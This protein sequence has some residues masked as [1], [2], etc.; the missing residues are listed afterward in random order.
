MNEQFAQSLVNKLIAGSLAGNSEVELLTELCRRL[1]DFGLPLLRVS[2]AAEQLHPTIGG[3]GHVWWRDA[4]V[5][6]PSFPR[7]DSSQGLEL[8]RRSPFD[9]LLETGKSNGRFRLQE[10]GQASE[11]PLFAELRQRG[12]SEYFAVVMRIDHYAT[13]SSARDVA[14]SWCTDRPDG[15]DETDVVLIERISPALALVVNSARST[16]T[17]RFLLETYLGSDAANRVLSGNVV[18]GRADLIEAAIWFSDLS[19]FT[20]TFDKESPT[21][22]LALLNEYANLQCEAIHAQGGQV[23]KFIG[24]GILATFKN[25]DR[26]DACESAAS[27][28]LDALHRAALLSRERE[29]RALPTTAV[30]IALHFGEVLYG[31]FGNPNRLDFT[32][33]GPAVNEASR[34]VALSG[35]LDQQLIISEVVAQALGKHRDRIAALGRHTLKGVAKP[36]LLFA[37]SQEPD[38][39]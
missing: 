8:Q 21:T 18:R 2:T 1:V 5:E 13:L 16:A 17:G 23:L 25:N 30:K 12:A 7:R 38:D 10:T 19:G 22:V 11:F 34:I 26:R 24:D 36:Q 28:A 14:F 3:Q 9:H 20:R 37:L 35:S 31:N 33:L 6:Q 27:A 32:V 29:S 15:F 39:F 4:P